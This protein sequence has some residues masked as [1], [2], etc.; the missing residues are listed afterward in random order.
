MNREQIKTFLDVYKARVSRTMVLIDFGNVEKWKNSLGWNVN[1]GK[2]SQLV[3]HFS[4]GNKQNRRFYYGSDF[5]KEEK[6]PVFS[7]WSRL[8]LEKAQWGKFEIVT[9]PV[10]YI[11]SR[12]NII[13]FEKKCDLDVEMA[14]DL[15]K[16]RDSYDSIILFSGD[17][18]LMHAVRYLKEEYQKSCIVFGARDHIGREV[19]DAKK[20]GIV[21]DIFFAQDFE[22]RLR[23]D[24]QNQRSAPRGGS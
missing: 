5:G 4:L 9:K 1:I 7:Q 3:K 8:I 24:A 11:H 18:D 19:F 14:I 2:L 22:Y 16:Y 17:G 20:A 13:G 21:E 23:G 6:N 12:D 15:V 10:K